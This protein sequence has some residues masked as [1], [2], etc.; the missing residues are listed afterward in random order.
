M[1]LKL[2]HQARSRGTL[3]AV[4]HQLAAFFAS[5]GGH[6][7]VVPHVARLASR[8]GI[9]RQAGG[10]AISAHSRSKQV[11]AGHAGQ[12]VSGGIAC[13][14][15]MHTKIACEATGEV[16]LLNAI[17]AMISTV[18]EQTLRGTFLTQTS[19]IQ[20]IARL[21]ALAHSLVRAYEA[22]GHSL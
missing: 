7:Q 13:K 1:I 18:A 21:A 20:S 8:G 3:P 6:I 5:V 12:T 16:H 17:E 9:A 19:A 15:G 10:W 14:T 22:V 11:V 2:A 4:G